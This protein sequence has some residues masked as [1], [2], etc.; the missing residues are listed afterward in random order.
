MGPRSSVTRFLFV[1]GNKR[2]FTDISMDGSI[3]PFI[4]VFVKSMKNRAKLLTNII[5]WVEFKAEGAT[6]ASKIP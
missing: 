4:S 2:F 1:A 3:K 5:K 6:R